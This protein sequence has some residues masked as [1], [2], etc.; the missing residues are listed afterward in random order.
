LRIAFTPLTANL[1]AAVAA[2]PALLD[3][4]D[5]KVS[6]MFWLAAPTGF[7]WPSTALLKVP[8]MSLMAFSGERP[9]RKTEAAALLSR[10][11]PSRPERVSRLIRGRLSAEIFLSF[12][13]FS[14]S[15]VTDYYNS[16]YN[17][18]N[19]FKKKKKGRLK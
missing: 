3:R 4:P 7:S 19:K 5:A 17:K 18:I 2:L 13:C 1:V 9:P 10:M 14:C 12:D 15:A 8:T 11:S 16:R 6:A